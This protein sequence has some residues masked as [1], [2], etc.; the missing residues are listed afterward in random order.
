MVTVSDKLSGNLYFL[1]FHFY[2]FLI[3]YSFINKKKTFKIRNYIEELE[4]KKNNLC[5]ELVC[6]SIAKQGDRQIDT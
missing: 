5:C 4:N 1:L 6:V 2:V 3:F